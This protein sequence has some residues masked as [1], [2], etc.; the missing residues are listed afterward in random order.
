MRPP[1]IERELREVSIEPGAEPFPA[2]RLDALNDAVRAVI[3]QRLIERGAIVAIAGAPGASK[4]VLSV[5]LGLHVA[6]G[7][8]WF[9]LKVACGPCIYFA[10]EAPGSVVMR[11][12]AASARKFPGASLPFYVVTANPLLGDEDHSIAEADRMIATII[13]VQTTE[14]NPVQLVFIDTL[15]SCLGTGDE[16]STGMVCIVNAAQ[17]IAQATG[18]TV[19]LVHHPSKMDAAGLRGHGSLLGKCDTV[20]SIETAPDNTTRIATLVKSRDFPAGLQLAYELE[21]VTLDQPDQ[22]GDV[23][24][25]IIVKPIPTP[26]IGRKRPDG[27]TQDCLLLDLERR[28]RTGETSWDLATVRQAAKDLGIRQNIERT[29][30]GL[31]TAGFLR[32]PD[33]RLIL[34]YPPERT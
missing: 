14:T 9:G 21:Q 31:K 34:S 30:S 3:V 20:I 5:D 10:A 13:D 7:A 29:I 12:K 4:T 33:S 26:K 16:N 19:I 2:Q 23:R 27:K 8:S 22:F 32:G 24:T 25:T 17:R 1:E 18:A 15:A 11:G 6:A 28:H